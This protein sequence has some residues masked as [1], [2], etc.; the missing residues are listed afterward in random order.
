MRHLLQNN[1]PEIH[2]LCERHD[3]VRLEA[4]G[5]VLTDS[6]KANSDVDLLY[7][8]GNAV[9]LLDTADNYFDF[10][11]ALEDLL[12]RKIDLVSAKDLSNPYLIAS[13]NRTK[14][15]LYERRHQE[16]AV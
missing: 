9:P 15:L 6:F 7:T 1:L 13:I 5:S 3:V 10:K 12:N 2:R 4:F 8:F 11:F 14:Q 16:V